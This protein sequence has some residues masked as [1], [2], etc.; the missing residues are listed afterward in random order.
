MKLTL[1]A[2]KSMIDK[3]YF[4]RDYVTIKKIEYNNE[5]NE[6]YNF[7]R[8]YIFYSDKTIDIDVHKTWS[9]V[10]CHGYITSVT[11]SSFVSLVKTIDLLINK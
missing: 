1:K 7:V 4:I 10:G 11:M 8:Y 2:L 5:E 9:I 3:D 6:D